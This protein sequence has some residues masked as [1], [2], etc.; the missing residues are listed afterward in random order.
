MI[1]FAAIGG[2]DSE[3][4]LPKYDSCSREAAFSLCSEGRHQCHENFCDAVFVLQ[5]GVPHYMFAE[6]SVASGASN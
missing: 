5:G 2:R 4:R 6:R 1:L 3:S